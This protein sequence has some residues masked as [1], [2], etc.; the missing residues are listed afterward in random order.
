MGSTMPGFGD[1]ILQKIPELS[2]EEATA[3]SS[4]QSKYSLEDVHRKTSQRTQQPTG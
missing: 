3:E 2:G 1:W 4:L